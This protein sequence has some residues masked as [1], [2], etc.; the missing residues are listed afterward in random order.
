ATRP[1]STSA[2]SSSST[3]LVGTTRASLR[4]RWNVIAQTWSSTSPAAAAT[5]SQGATPVTIGSTKPMPPTS[6]APP[7]NPTKAAATLL[8]HVIC[9][10]SAGNGRKAFPPP[11][12]TYAAA[13]STWA[14][15][16]TT[17]MSSDSLSADTSSA[18][19]SRTASSA[20]DA[21]NGQMLH[22]RHLSLIKLLP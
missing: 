17:F 8:P 13:S 12:S 19:T 5:V 21:T 16:S 20:L 3:T 18:D 15:H 7:T 9:L 4:D 6:S 10:R 1:M 2:A 22:I 11:A 14:I